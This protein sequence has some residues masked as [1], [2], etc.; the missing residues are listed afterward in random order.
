MTK[1]LL[2]AKFLKLEKEAF[3]YFQPVWGV[4]YNQVDWGV[5]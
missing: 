2:K 1:I 4:I 3:L 5:I